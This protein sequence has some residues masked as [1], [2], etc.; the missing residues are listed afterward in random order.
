[1]T[2][3]REVAKMSTVVDSKVKLINQTYGYKEFL[4][5]ADQLWKT[6]QSEFEVDPLSIF[7]KHQNAKERIEQLNKRIADWVENRR[8]DFE[9]K[10]QGYQLVLNQAGLRIDLKVPFDPEHPNASVDALLNQVNSGLQRYLSVLSST[11]VQAVTTIRYSIKVQKL[12]LEKVEQQAQKALQNAEQLQKELTTEKL[13]DFEI[14]KGRIVQQLVAL[15]TEE[16][17]LRSE[18]QTAIQ[19]QKPEGS[20]IRLMEMLDGSTQSQ[21]VDLRGLII[22]MLE[23]GDDSVDLDDLMQDITSLFKKNQVSIYIVPQSGIN[24]E[25]R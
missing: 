24:Q 4:D 23:N 19:K 14:F 2:A 8:R 15:E 12:P 11:I 20:E 9:Q 7:S 17:S 10:C 3:W 18:I 13:S 22:K 16:Q 5:L 25:K 1:M 21:R 6:L